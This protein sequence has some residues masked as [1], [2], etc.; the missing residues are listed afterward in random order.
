MKTRSLKFALIW[1]Y[2][3]NFDCSSCIPAVIATEAEKHWGY[4]SLWYSSVALWDYVDLGQ[5]E[6]GPLCL[7]RKINENVWESKFYTLQTCSGR[8]PRGFSP[9]IRGVTGLLGWPWEG[10][11]HPHSCCRSTAGLKPMYS[12]VATLD[13]RCW[14]LETLFLYPGANRHWSF[15]EWQLLV[16]DFARRASPSNKDICFTA[17]ADQGEHKGKIMKYGLV[18]FHLSLV[19][20]SP[21]QEKGFREL[22]NDVN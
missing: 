4:W 19:L 12:G 16:L 20:K 1:W 15:G 17:A 22:S 9:G 10:C 8:F 13:F 7:C 5:I 21:S 11:S 2:K 14:V 3:L 6:I 18:Y